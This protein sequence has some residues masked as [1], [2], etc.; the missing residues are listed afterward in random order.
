[1]EM[2]KKIHVILYDFPLFAGYFYAFALQSS[3]YI[4]SILFRKLQKT[5]GVIE[6]VSCWFYSLFKHHLVCITSASRLH[7]KHTSFKPYVF[8]LLLPHMRGHGDELENWQMKS[9][10]IHVLLCSVWWIWKFPWDNV[11]IPCKHASGLHEIHT[12]SSH[13]ANIITLIQDYKLIL[14]SIGLLI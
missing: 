7:G 13:M 12:W 11:W 8:H 6:L 9:H 2:H 1:M 3:I 10:G 4:I 5:H 14:K